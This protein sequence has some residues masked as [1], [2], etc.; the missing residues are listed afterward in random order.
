[1][2]QI[3]NYPININVPKVAFYGNPAVSTPIRINYRDEFISSPL[4]DKYLDKTAILLEAKQNA[5]IQELMSSYNLPIKVNEKAIETLKESGHLQNTRLLAIKIYSSL[6]ME[7]KKGVNLRQLQEAAMVHDVGKVL[8]PNNILNKKGALTPKER[9]I[10]ELHSELGYELLKYKGF[11]LKTLELIRNHHQNINGTG[12]PAVKEGYNH[13]IAT[14]ILSAA[15]KVS[16][17]AEKRSYKEA[18]SKEQVLDILKNDET[19]SPEIY[20]AIEKVL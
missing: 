20:S 1:M 6:P 12:Y 17:L 9:E 19:I 2:T 16:A 8:I 13:D 10:M 3:Y 18:L 5:R 11:D 7:L 15:D 4:V 14:Q